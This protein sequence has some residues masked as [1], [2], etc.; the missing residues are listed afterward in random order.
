MVS[1]E[2]LG[3]FVRHQDHKGTGDEWATTGKGNN[4]WRVASRET[5]ALA[6]YG[7]RQSAAGDDRRP[8]TTEVSHRNEET[9]ATDHRLNTD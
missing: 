3:N 4:G 6:D 5:R 7:I 1:K 2:S 9:R 8:W